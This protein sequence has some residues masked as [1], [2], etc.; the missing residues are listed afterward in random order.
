MRYMPGPPH[1]RHKKATT[2][3]DKIKRERLREYYESHQSIA[4]Q[5]KARDYSYPPPVYPTMP[6][7][8]RSLACGAKTR[9]GTPC[10]LTSIYINGRCKLHGG[11]STGPKSAEGRAKCALNGSQPKRKKQSP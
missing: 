4:E 1:R 3:D 9:A 8:L 6:D 10:K 11:L 7:D 2:M 5:W